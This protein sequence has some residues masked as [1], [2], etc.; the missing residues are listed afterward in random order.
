MT[1]FH[2]GIDNFMNSH[3]K[4]EEDRVKCSY[5]KITGITFTDYPILRVENLILEDCI[6]E[7]CNT[8]HFDNCK[9]NQCRFHGAETIYADC[10]PI[11]G[12]VFEHLRCDNDCILCL[13]DSDIS[14]CTFKDVKLTN[15]AHLVNGVGDVW[16]ESCSFEKISTDRKDLELFCCEETV[17]KFFKKTVRF[18]IAD[19]GSCK[20]L[21]NVLY[22]ADEKTPEDPM[23][24]LW[25]Q[26]MNK[27]LDV[28]KAIELMRDG[29]SWDASQWDAHKLGL[30]I[31]DLVV[32]IPVYNCLTRANLRT[33]GDLVSLDFKQILSIKHLSKTVV[34]EVVEL[35]HSL[36][37]TGS[38]WE[39]LI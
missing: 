4:I 27:G 28:E 31:G 34:R 10:T 32:Q 13:E 33:V 16:I 1:I 20:G 12:C 21:D 9:V 39:Y 19:T 15:Q 24:D 6:F 7:N 8:I 5:A 18:C 38:A 22:I 25:I 36:D 11:D 23:G 37:I 17:G 26:A 30:V 3:I 29:V 2:Y 14:F 35:L